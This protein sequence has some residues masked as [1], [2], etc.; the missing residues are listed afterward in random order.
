MLRVKTVYAQ[1]ETKQVTLNSISN[2]FVITHVLHVT[3]QRTFI[4]VLCGA[5]NVLLLAIKRI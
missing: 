5:F 3:V 1:L 4:N 2:D